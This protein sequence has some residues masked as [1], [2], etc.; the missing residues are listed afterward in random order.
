MIESKPWNWSKNENDSWLS[1]AVESD[2]I[3]NSWKLKNFYKLLDLGCGLGRHTIYF[4]KNGFKV[5]AVDLSDYAINSAKEWAQKEQ[6]DIETT[7]CDMI[8]LPF[9]NDTFDCIIAYNVIYH[10]DTDGFIKTIEEIKRVLKYNGE[11]FITLISKNTF[12][13]KTTDTYGRIDNNTILIDED[14]TEK[15][16]PHF[17][18][19]INDIK[20]YFKDFEFITTPIEQTEYNINHTEYYLTHFNFIIRKKYM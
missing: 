1:P 7:V 8:N 15:N 18:V 17:F 6:L 14:A 16:V 11:A 13:Y 9:E 20:K 2:Y 3:I 5:T 4:S 12:G 19:D 10:T